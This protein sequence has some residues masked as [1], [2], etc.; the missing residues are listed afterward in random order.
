MPEHIGRRFIKGQDVAPQN[1]G[2]Q[3]RWPMPP[4]DI[5]LDPSDLRYVSG[6]IFP[7]H[8]KHPVTG[9]QTTEATRNAKLEPVDV[10]APD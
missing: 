10:D 6:Y 4:P 9:R 2:D 5:K 8:F 1:R 3:K 7:F